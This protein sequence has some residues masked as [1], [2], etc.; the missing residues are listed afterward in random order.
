MMYI[1][2]QISKFYEVFAQNM[3]TPITFHNIAF[4]E[5]PSMQ[6][7]IKIAAYTILINTVIYPNGTFQ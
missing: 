1:H 5:P 6:N 4:I 3:S 2:S 7:P